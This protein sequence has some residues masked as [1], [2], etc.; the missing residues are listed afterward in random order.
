VA[1]STAVFMLVHGLRDWPA[2]IV[3]G[4]TYCLLVGYTNNSR[5][6]LG[7]GPVIWA[8][9]ITNGALWAYTVYM[10]LNQGGDWRFF[11]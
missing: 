10:H 9:G 2:V 3:C 8:H 5:R 6:R 4:I 1:A 7:L 11:V